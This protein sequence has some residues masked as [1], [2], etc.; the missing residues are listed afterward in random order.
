MQAQLPRVRWNRR[1]CLRSPD[2]CPVCA[3]R[4]VRTVTKFW[5]VRSG[6]GPV[7]RRDHLAVPSVAAYG[8]LPPVAAHCPASPKAAI[9]GPPLSSGNRLLR[10]RRR[11]R[12]RA[13][14]GLMCVA[15]RTLQTVVLRHCQRAVMALFDHRPVVRNARPKRPANG[16]L[17]LCRRGGP[18]PVREY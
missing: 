9:H 3:R 14:E 7:T 18:A 11:H 17:E 16:I 15:H 4:S 2:L 5:V 6:S 1:P 13:S 8:R 10:P 12:A